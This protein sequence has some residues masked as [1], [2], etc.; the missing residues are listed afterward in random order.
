MLINTYPQLDS[1]QGV[2]D[3]G[4]LYPSRDVLITSSPSL[5]EPC[6]RGG[7]DSVRAKGVA[8][9]KETVFQTHQADTGDT[10]R[11][12]KGQAGPNPSER[13]GQGPT[14]NKELV[15]VYTCREREGT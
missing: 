15:A 12:A 4:A 6:G 11:S 10:Q 7:G 13:S 14:P 9:S 3:C 8:D 2:R 5:R 1:S